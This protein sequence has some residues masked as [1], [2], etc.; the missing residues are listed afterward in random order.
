MYLRLENIS[1]HFN[2]FVANHNISFSV[3]AGKIHGILGENGAG[4]TTLMNIMSGLYQPDTGKI[5]LED[6]LVKINSPN[7]AIKLGI[8]MVY[9]HFMLVPNLTVTE[10]IIL[11]RENNWCLN[12]RQKQQ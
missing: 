12:L 10:N 6:K 11:G 2:S 4:K 3:D 9:Q 5:Y 1:K 8:G 7:A